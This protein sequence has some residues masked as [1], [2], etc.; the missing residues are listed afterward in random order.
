MAKNWLYIDSF[1]QALSPLGFDGTIELTGAGRYN[2]WG[3]GLKFWYTTWNTSYRNKPYQWLVYGDWSEQQPH[4]YLCI[5]PDKDKIPGE[6]HIVKVEKDLTASVKNIRDVEAKTTQSK[7][8]ELYQDYTPGEGNNEYLQRK[9]IVDILTIDKAVKQ[10]ENGALIIPTKDATGVMWGY[11]IIAPSGKKLFCRGQSMDAMRHDIPGDGKGPV[12]LCEGYATGASI[13]LA[14]GQ[15]VVVAFNANNLSKV[16]SSL[17]SLYP[18]REIII[19][20]DNDQ[21]KTHTGRKEAEKAAKNIG[22]ATVVMP[23]FAEEDL[24]DKPTDYND[25]HVLYGLEALKD[26]IDKQVVNAE[27]DKPQ[28]ARELIRHT[29]PDEEKPC[30][31]RSVALDVMANHN[32]LHSEG[33]WWKYTTP[34]WAMISQAELHRLI[35]ECDSQKFHTKKRA[36]EIEY[37]IKVNLNVDKPLFNNVKQWEIPI[38]NG[39][40]NLNTRKMRPHEHSDMLDRCIPVDYTVSQCPIW[41]ASLNKWFENNTETEREEKK[42]AL[43]MFFGYLLM[44]HAKYKKALMLLGPS[45]TGKSVVQA[46]AT[47]L[48]GQEVTCSIPLEKMDDARAIAPIVGAVLNNVNE[49]SSGALFSDGGFKRLVSS[50]DET[51]QID[52]KHIRPFNYL[53]TAK[54]VIYTNLLP[55][56]NDTSM[57]TYNR[58]LVIEFSR[59]FKPEEMD[60]NLIDTL[61]TELKGIL[62]WAMRGAIL[63]YEAHGEWPE[64]ESSKR[65]LEEH[66][67]AQNQVAIFVEENCL[68]DQFTRTQVTKLWTAYRSAK[69]FGRITMPVF[70][71]QLEAAGYNVISDI[72]HGVHSKYV[73]GLK[74]AG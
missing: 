50:G 74:L 67:M 55:G 40:Y 31:P 1:E 59:V 52:P 72:S 48:V 42:R 64:L 19:C 47:A 9:Q 13:R 43:Q 44:P 27:G 69:G 8:I 21:F 70:I 51:V 12:Y 28:Y 24:T 6:R 25:Y 45:N 46:I 15:P 4:G 36:N 14:T 53:P 68:R 22:N 33:A 32:L 38:A 10:K 17:T 34:K 58:L 20:A 66:R 73:N 60:S 35:A 71:S 2:R 62:A 16:A 54:H 3:K 39:V 7:A 23:D 18:S 49:P 5:P 61:K 57:A 63:L 30:H 26:D 11:Q 37:L 65:I 41:L 56:V 29:R